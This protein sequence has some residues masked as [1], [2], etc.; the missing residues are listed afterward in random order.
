MPSRPLKT[1]KASLAVRNA[2]L[3]SRQEAKKDGVSLGIAAG[4]TAF[5]QSELPRRPKVQHPLYQ[6]QFV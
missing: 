1:R 3:Q 6:S 2:H 5:R 4:K